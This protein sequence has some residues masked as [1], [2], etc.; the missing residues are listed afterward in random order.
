MIKRVDGPLPDEIGGLIFEVMR[1]MRGH[2]HDEATA[3]RLTPQQVLMLHLLREQPT[4]MSGLADKLHCDASNV[5]GLADRLEARGLVE[6][7]HDPDDRRVKQLALTADGSTLISDLD[8]RIWTNSPVSSRL[9][10]TE[11]TQLRHLL[12]KT[13]D[14]PTDTAIT[15]DD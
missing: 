10:D 1:S 12:L 15:Q 14:R 3:A 9:D 4:S 11:Q 7:R 2:I 6:R 13:L 8:R 5:T